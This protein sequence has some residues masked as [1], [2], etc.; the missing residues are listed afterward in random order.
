MRVLG[1][2]PGSRRTGYGLVEKNGNRLRCVAQGAIVPAARLDLAHR[3]HAI[4]ARAGELME[5]VLDAGADDVNTEGESFEV[6]TPPAVLE[7]VKEALA[8][9][10][11][12]VQSAELTRVATQEVQVAAK[13]A[14]ALLKLVDELEE[15]DDVQKV[16]A[17]F[18]I[19]DEVLSKLAH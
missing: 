11:V 3:L 7:A 6:L 1:L 19:P 16:H 2:D 18:N 13:D 12:A 17:N 15:H 8:K 5:I 9:K 10:G 4:A 14:G